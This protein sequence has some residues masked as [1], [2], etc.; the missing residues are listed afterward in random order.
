MVQQHGYMQAE[1]ITQHTHWH[2][3]PDYIETFAEFADVEFVVIDK[4][5]NVTEFKKEL[6][7]NE[8]YY[9]LANG[10]K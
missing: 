5:T 2:L 6:R 4:N 3:T 10:L 7:W 1:H 8:M 9:M